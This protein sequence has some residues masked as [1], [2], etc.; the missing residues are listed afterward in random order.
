MS[1]DSKSSYFINDQK[2]TFTDVVQLLKDKGI[3]MSQNRFLILQVK[4]IK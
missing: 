1:R 3:D 4:I 2:S